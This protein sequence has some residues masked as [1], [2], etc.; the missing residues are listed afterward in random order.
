MATHVSAVK[1]IKQTRKRTRIKRS[2]LTLV[3]H[4]IRLVRSLLAKKDKTKALEELRK[5][6]SLLDKAAGKGVIPANTASRHKSRLT[7]QLNA[8]A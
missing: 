7:R 8:L 1:R 5:T 3:R 6:L 2:H 4:Q